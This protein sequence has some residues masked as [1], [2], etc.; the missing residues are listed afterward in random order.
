MGK[1]CSHSGQVEVNEVATKLIS[2]TFS[3]SKVKTKDLLNM[4]DPKKIVLD[5]I[6]A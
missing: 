6:Y 2:L 4:D 5:T 3:L 1:V